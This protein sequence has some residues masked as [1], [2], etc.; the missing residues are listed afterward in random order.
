MEEALEV[1]GRNGLGPVRDAGLLDSALARPQASAIGE[2]VYATINLKAAALLH[3]IVNNHSLIDG[4]KRL[5]LS[6]TYLF[7]VMNG[8]YLAMSQ[9]ELFDFMI[10]VASTSISA[11]ELELK[12]KVA[13]L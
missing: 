2:D 10:E 13:A 4:N 7:L 3:S 12:L 5:A 6:L 11:Q 1:I 8:Y 9:G